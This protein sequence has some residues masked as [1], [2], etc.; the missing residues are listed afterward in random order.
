MTA[1][2]ECNKKLSPIVTELFLRGRILNI[3]LDFI[4]QSYFKLPKT[5]RLNSTHYFIM[6][7]PNK[8][9]LQQ[10]A[11][12]HI[13]DIDFKDFMKLYKDYNEKPY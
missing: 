12:N 6:K 1:D 3:C 8:G 4:S 10:T 7:I 11:S 13:S 5:I 2:M 9:E